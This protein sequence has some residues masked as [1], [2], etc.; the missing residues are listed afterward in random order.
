MQSGNNCSA[1]TVSAN[2]TYSYDSQGRLSAINRTSGGNWSKS[3]TYNTLGLLGYETVTIDGL[4][5]GI[6]HYYDAWQ[7]P[8]AVSYPDTDTNPGNDEVVKVNYNALGLPNLLCKSYL[9]SSGQY[10]CDASP[11]YADAASYDVAGRLTAVQYPAGGNLWRTQT[12]Y[13]WTLVQNGGLLWTIKVGSSQGSDNRFGRAYHYNPFGEVL[14]DGTAANNFTYDDL[15]RLTSAYGQ[16]FSYDAVGR[17]G[18]GGKTYSSS[19][20]YHAPKSSNYGSHSYDVNGNLISAGT[21][22]FTWNAE[23]RLQSATKNGVT[24]S[25]VYDVD[26]NRIKKTSDGVVTRTFFP[27]HYEEEGSTPIKHYSFNGQIIATRRGT[28]LSY[29]HTDHLSSNSVSTNITG[30]QTASRTYHAYG[31]TRSSSGTLPTDRTFTGQ[32]QDGTGLMYFNARY[33]DSAL[34]QFLSPDTLVPD[35][36][37]VFD[38]NRFMYARGNPLKYTD[39][40]GHYTNDEIMQH[41]GCGD[42]ACVEGYFQD[43]KAYAGLWGWLYILQNANHGDRIVS[44]YGWKSAAIRGTFQSSRNFVFEIIADD[45][46]VWH[47]AHFAL[48]PAQKFAGS[49]SLNIGLP[50]AVFTA[51]ETKHQFRIRPA[52]IDKVGVGV[53]LVK[54]GTEFGPQLA[55]SG[56]PYAAVAGMTWTV[57]GAGATVYTD[58]VQP[59][60]SVLQN[61]DG[62]AY[63]LIV[64]AIVELTAERVAPKGQPYIGPATDI[65]RSIWPSLCWGTECFSK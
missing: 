25:Y 10:W 14:N 54:A 36:G 4:T 55:K 64:D 41:F 7:R 1:G 63:A 35:A 9:H 13:G 16:S 43:G 21:A 3:F 46:Y 19:F 58:L 28:T 18:G 52:E 37:V 29:L 12:Y 22:S 45:G 42:W 31:T 48:H 60:Q 56:N 53:G 47:P 57:A 49:Y 8:Y 39:P 51:A 26:G 61:N 30:T 62:P 59:I 27:G 24:E 11:R 44:T 15:G 65:T 32:K 17:M 6:S 20:P 5:R 38:Y 2:Y 23:N 50:Y 34:G 40:S 33:Y